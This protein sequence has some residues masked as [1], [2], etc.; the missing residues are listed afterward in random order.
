MT[1]RSAPVD[2]GIRR[3]VLWGT[4]D[5]G[6]P[7]VR[8]LLQG[9]RANGVEVIEC[10]ADIWSGV[11]DKSQ[12]KG[13][14]PWIGMLA[15]IA[16]SYPAL[17]W[18]YLR[19]PKHDW[20]LLGYPAIPDIFAIRCFAW[21]RGTR[22]AMD[23]FLSAY[24][25]VVEDRKLVGRH[26]P[27]A[28]ALRIVEWMA[29]R[30][31]N[32][33]FMDTGVHAARMD[34][35]FGL[36]AG[37]CG[38]VWVGVELQAFDGTGIALPTEPV[39]SAPMKVLFYGQFIPLHGL[40]TIVEAA[41]RLRDEPIDWLVIGRGQESAR[42]DA[43]LLADPLPRLRRLDWAEYGDLLGHLSAADVC[44]GIFGTSDKAASVIP[45]KVFQ[46]LAARK[47]LVTRDSPGM[48]ELLGDAKLADVALVAAGDAQALANALLSW[49]RQPPLADPA[50]D[51]LVAR[52][53]PEAIGRQCIDL[54]RGR[55][56]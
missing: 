36:P 15:R 33:A 35:L 16:L 13:A 39:R 3:V 22:V 27:I 17:I 18:R 14:L 52:F 50:R 32:A 6:K 5:T 38:R 37:S 45:N 21:L 43:M 20:V 46:I 53:T 24:D 11:Q 4:C 19:L 12:L 9:L 44:L 25:T 28:S 31:A 51:A 29:V 41:Q 55:A 2:A 42:V 10:R 54:L 30:L 48:R 8:I 7:R 23:W 1:E 40:Q 34:G 26:H 49:H 47:P 56:A